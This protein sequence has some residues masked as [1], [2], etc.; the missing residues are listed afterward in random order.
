MD[1]IKQLDD[2]EIDLSKGAVFEKGIVY[3]VE[4]LERTKLVNGLIGVANP[5]SSTSRLDVLVRLI[6]DQATA[7]GKVR[8]KYEGPL[9]LEV[10]P[11]AF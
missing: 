6:T 5:K 8:R 11:Q 7:F 4:L 10:A 2:L 9:Y 3:V 1:C